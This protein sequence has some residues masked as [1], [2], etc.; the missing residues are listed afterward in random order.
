MQSL[1]TKTL[2]P[3]NIAKKFELLLAVL[4]SCRFL[5][6]LLQL[7]TNPCL[8]GSLRLL[9]KKQMPFIPTASAVALN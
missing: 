1:V 5:L 3:V 9:R 8:G 2:L 7:N 6:A 4:M